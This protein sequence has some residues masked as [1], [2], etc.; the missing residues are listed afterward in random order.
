MCFKYHDE[1]FFA[2]G[3]SLKKLAQEVGTPFY[4]YSSDKLTR[5]FQSYQQALARWPGRAAGRMWFPQGK[6]TWL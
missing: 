6:C 3:V 2:E 1:E 5:N 4:C